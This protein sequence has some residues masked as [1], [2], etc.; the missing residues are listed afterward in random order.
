MPTCVAVTCWGWGDIWAFEGPEEARLH[1]L[2]DTCDVIINSAEDVA[3]NWNYL[4]LPRMCAEV[5][6][7]KV[8]SE[9][10]RER[11]STAESDRVREERMQELSRA[12]YDALCRKSKTPPSAHKTICEMIVRDRIRTDEWHRRENARRSSVTEAAKTTAAAAPK[13][14]KAK[15]VGGFALTAKITL[16][17][18]KEGKAYGKDNNPKRAG[19]ASAALFEK[20]KDGMTVEQAA[21]AG[22]TAAALKWDSEHDFIK[23][24]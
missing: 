1:P 8:A 13:E 15:T 20:Y 17:K 5:L 16:G 24:A 19:S 23:I 10:A 21:A 7:D 14:E 2:I 9:R 3:K 22:L 12:V 6:G 18:D 4:F 11:I